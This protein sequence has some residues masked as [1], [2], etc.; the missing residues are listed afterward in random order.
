MLAGIYSADSLGSLP[1]VQ[2]LL[3][4]GVGKGS[5]MVLLVAGVGTSLSTLGPVAKAMGRRTAI[6]YAGS[7][8]A[9]AALIGLGL[10]LAH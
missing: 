4:E 1:W 5:A 2:S 8:V 3:S 9:L 10:N 7:I 6:L